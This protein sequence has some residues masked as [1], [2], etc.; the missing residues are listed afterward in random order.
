LGERADRE[1]CDII[2]S[3]ADARPV[4]IGERQRF[5]GRGDGIAG[6]DVRRVDRRLRD[7]YASDGGARVGSIASKVTVQPASSVT[8]GSPPMSW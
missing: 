3:R 6:R 7:R 4:E 5:L 2:A 1:G 8:A